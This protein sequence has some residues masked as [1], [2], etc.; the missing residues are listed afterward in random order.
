MNQV[1][2]LNSENRYE[3]TIENLLRQFGDAITTGKERGELVT[4]VLVSTYAQIIDNALKA[5][6]EGKQIVSP[7]ILEDIYYYQG[8][9]NGY[10]DL[11]NAAPDTKLKRFE[12]LDAEFESLKMPMGS[13]NMA[14]FNMYTLAQKEYDL[15]SGWI[16]GYI[17]T[18]EML[19]YQRPDPDQAVDFHAVAV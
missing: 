2:A 13:K 5:I 8:W 14:T 1:T 11:M 4:D 12:E 16:N 19:G 17:E 7:R 18:L 15:R 3:Q 9:V 10:Y 6:S